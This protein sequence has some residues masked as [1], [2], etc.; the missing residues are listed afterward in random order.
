MRLPD[1]ADV[2]AQRTRARRRPTRVVVAR[3][4]GE[5]DPCA[6]HEAL[7]R[8]EDDGRVVAVRDAMGP[9]MVF[10]IDVPRSPSELALES[11]QFDHS[12]S[13]LYRIAAFAAEKP[14]SH[15][16][17]RSRPLPGEQRIPSRAP[18]CATARV[19]RRPFGFV[20]RREW[21]T[22]PR[23]RSDNTNMRR[24]H[25]S[26]VLLCSRPAMPR[27]RRSGRLTPSSRSLALWGVKSE[28]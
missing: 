4:H 24:S 17:A 9:R 21:P 25:G 3:Q 26:L 5:F 27:P 8:I 22:L 12:R 28:V 13:V 20:K 6:R 19:S 1:R 15:R 2:S 10:S 11:D 16:P 18:A 7:P 23:W 14:S